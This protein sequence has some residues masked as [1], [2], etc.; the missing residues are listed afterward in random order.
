MHRVKTEFTPGDLIADRYEVRRVLGRG[1]MGRVYL[2]TDR[3]TG[4]R[5]A[6]KT[7]LPQYA[8]NEY[9]VRRF[10]REVTAI[11]RF[12]HPAIV[13]IYDARRV[14]PLMFYTMD[15]VQGKSL[16]DWLSERGRLGLGSTVRILALLAHALE[17]AH[18]F[19][20]HRDISP[21]NVMILSNGTIRLLDFGLVKLTDADAAFT[22]I[23]ISLGKQHYQAPEQR[24]SAAEVDPRAD[25]YSMG[26]LFYEMLSGKLPFPDVP[27]TELVPNLPSQCDGFVAKAMADLPEKRFATAR[28]F[29]LALMDIYDQATGPKP[30]EAQP[31]APEPLAR[32]AS[33][34]VARPPMAAPAR[35]AAVWARPGEW[36][37]RLVRWRQRRGG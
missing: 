7:I 14:G 8:A 23:G 4:Q 32:E 15:Y 31:P 36:W 19:T 17:H 29:R 26:V 34:Q 11:R 37:R 35:L 10:I 33:Q 18:Q 25:I 2:V 27:L 5:L 6:L 9:A 13:K 3:E 1:G 21:E 28:E 12:N 30:P 20:I 16:R 22:R 24:A